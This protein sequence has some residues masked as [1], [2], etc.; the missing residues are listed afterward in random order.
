MNEYQ[1]DFMFKDRDILTSVREFTIK[2]VESDKPED[3]IA[4][5][6]F[7]RK[8][9]GKFFANKFEETGIDEKN[10]PEVDA[11]SDNESQTKATESRRKLLAKKFREKI[12]ERPIDD[13]SRPT[14]L[15]YANT[16]IYVLFRLFQVLF[17]NLDVLF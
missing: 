12:L 15:L 14:C 6:A 9:F 17:I 13:I 4:A 2:T 3:K 11:D 7:M 16:A 10:D 5:S 1:F 8:F